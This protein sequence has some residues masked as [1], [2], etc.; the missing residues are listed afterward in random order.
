LKLPTWN[1]RGLSGKENE[2]IEECQ[3]V[4]VGGAKAKKKIG[5]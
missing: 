4:K 2:L 1:I 5:T 3:K